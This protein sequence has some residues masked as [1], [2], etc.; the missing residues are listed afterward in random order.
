MIQTTPG[1]ANT[2]EAAVV[3]TN[4]A[5]ITSGT[6]TFHLVAMSGPNSGKWWDSG[7]AT[8]AAAEASAGSATFKGGATWTLSIAAAAW[9]NGVRY[10]MYAKESGGLNIL[11]DVPIL[12]A[13]LTGGAGSEDVTITCQDASGPLDGVAVW[14]SLD[15]AGSQVVAGVAYSNASGIVTFKLDPGTIW[16][17]RQLAGKTFTPDPEQETV[18][19]T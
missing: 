4:G 6:V 15:E 7:G 18:V 17:H 3:N 8:W 5:A 14:I 11:Y 10:A 12:C 16:I 9:T 2:V 1:V 13:P 19:A